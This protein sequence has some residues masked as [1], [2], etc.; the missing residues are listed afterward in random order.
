MQAKQRGG[1]L[2]HN[3]TNSE[4]KTATMNRDM[5]VDLTGIV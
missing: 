5:T 3:G 2:T 4:E 1:T